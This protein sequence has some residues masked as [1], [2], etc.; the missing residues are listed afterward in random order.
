MR[1][2]PS[3]AADGRRHQANMAWDAESSVAAAAEP[4]RPEPP[5]FT[6]ADASTAQDLGE[7]QRIEWVRLKKGGPTPSRSLLSFG[8]LLLQCAECWPVK[9]VQNVKPNNGDHIIWNRRVANGF[10]CNVAGIAD[11]VGEFGSQRIV[12]FGGDNAKSE[13]HKQ[14]GVPPASGTNLHDT[15]A[16]AHTSFGQDGSHNGLLM[17]VADVT[18][19][20]CVR[21]GVTVERRRLQFRHRSL[22]IT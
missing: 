19:E 15:I 8:E 16:L 7:V 18:V 11:R 20:V 5:L 12:G 14:L 3:A 2:Q 21:G 10:W 1:R 4:G 9:V 6:E 22:P 17:R 13:R